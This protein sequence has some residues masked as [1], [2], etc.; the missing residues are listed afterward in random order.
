M[1]REPRVCL[2]IA[3]DAPSHPRATVIGRA[4]IV[5]RPSESEAWKRIA[6]QMASGILGIGQLDT[7]Y[8]D[9]TADFP[10]WLV[11][12]APYRMTTWRGGGWNR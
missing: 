6:R 8:I 10:R 1:L 12:V 4:E 11:R 5:A 7:G 9:R 3:D 2:S